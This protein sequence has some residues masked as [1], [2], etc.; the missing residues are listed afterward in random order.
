MP[1]A[2]A[3]AKRGAPVDRMTGGPT[4]DA[5]RELALARARLAELE[6]LHESW[7]MPERR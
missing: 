3:A 4:E 5:V 1:K 6:A 7:E 2:N